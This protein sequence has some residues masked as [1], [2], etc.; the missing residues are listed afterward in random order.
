VALLELV[1]R[2]FSGENG[3]LRDIA[4]KLYDGPKVG[5]IAEAA[6]SLEDTPHVAT[7]AATALALVRLGGLTHEDRWLDRARSLLRTIA[8]RVSGA[9]LFA[10]GSAL[11]G[12]LLSTPPA[13]IVVD[14]EGPGAERLLRTAYRAW[15]PNAFVFRGFPGRPFSAPFDGVVSSGD[16]E[17]RAYVC[18]GQV[19][20]SPVTEA[21][22]LVA[23]LKDRRAMPAP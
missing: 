3:L 5:G 17:A 12:R 16:G 13:T 15:H 22:K 14:G 21:S 9:G 19:C 10:A 20:A 18:L 6:Y 2:E 8:G 7:N 11:A 1:D 4:P 23:L